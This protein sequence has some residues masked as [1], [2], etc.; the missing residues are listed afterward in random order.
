[1]KFTKTFLKSNL[2]G[3][4]NINVFIK[5]RNQRWRWSFT[6]QTQFF[7][8]T[9]CVN[10]VSWSRRQDRTVQWTLILSFKMIFKALFY[11]EIRSMF[12]FYHRQGQIRPKS[13]RIGIQESVDHVGKVDFLSILFCKSM[14]HFRRI[15][16]NKNECA[17]DPRWSWV[18]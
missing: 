4:T 8:K 16:L 5:L 17:F 15:W 9:K 7:V 2:S 1:M 11:V 10:A 3:N 14:C 13:K 18:R 6:Q 12:R